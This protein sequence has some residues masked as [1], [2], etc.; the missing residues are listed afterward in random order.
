[1]KIFKV[2]IEN[3]RQYIGK[4]CLEFSTTDKNITII[5]GDNGG[6]KSNLMNAIVWCLFEDEMF[7]SKNNEGRQIINENIMASINTKETATA[8]VSVTIGED[9]P[10]FEFVRSSTFSKSVTGRTDYLESEFKGYHITAGGHDKIGDPEWEI[11]KQFIPKDLR[12]FFFFDGEKMDQ[13]FEDTSSVKSNVERISQIDVLNDVISTMNSTIR[14]IERDMGKL[15]PEGQE[16]SEQLQKLQD[17]KIKLENERTEL[18]PIVTQYE[19]NKRKIDEYLKNNSNEIVKQKSKLRGS[20]SAQRD[21]VLD[22]ISSLK[23]E[24]KRIIA[25]AIPIVYSYDALEFAAKLIDEETNKGTLPPN[26]KDVFLKELLDRGVCI[27][28]RTLDDDTCRQNIQDL[29]ER[30][31][32]SDIAYDATQGKYTIKN[33][34]SGFDFRPKIIEKLQKQMELETELQK[35]NEQLEAI[36]EELTNYD[37]F[38]ISEM[39][40]KRRTIETQINNTNSRIGF[41]NGRL[42]TI[43]D[44]INTVQDKLAQSSKDY[45]KYTR[46]EKQ[47]NYAIELLNQ[48]KL[49]KNKIITEVRVRLEK[50]TR[51]YFFKM[52][53]KKNA[54]SDVRIL[55]FGNKYKISVLSHNRAEC[56]GDLSAGER[57]VLALSF[58]AALYSVSGYNVPVIIDTPLGRISGATR[59]NI[60][61][62]LPEYLSETQLIMTMTDTEYTDEVRQAMNYAVGGEY[63]VIYDEETQTSKVVIM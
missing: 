41:I 13:Y 44:D 24:M 34:M 28:G 33:I 23:T 19:D 50:K 10:E 52:I 21:Q 15:S 39:E 63:K 42:S 1:M 8:T 26:I 45:Q 2:E 43:N 16:F 53:W 37:E 54:Y 20:I 35:F 32:P 3:Y 49:I 47:K 22:Q 5:Q 31:V 25:D 56:L 11:N 58:T 30:I 55:D 60:A 48:F 38:E 17:E 18:T 61:S 4:T 27:C 14:A 40:N 12:S 62:A 29:L 6:G 36:S 9:K 57:Q 59:Y 7:K 46:L 51:E